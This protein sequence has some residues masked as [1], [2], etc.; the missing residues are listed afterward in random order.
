MGSMKP[1]SG[2]GIERPGTSGRLLLCIPLTNVMFVSE[3][4][5]RG[6]ILL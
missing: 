5:Y 6:S 4:F 1:L 3:G 2:T